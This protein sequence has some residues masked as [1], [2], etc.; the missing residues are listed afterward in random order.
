ARQSLVAVCSQLEPAEPGNKTRLATRLSA[1]ASRAVECDPA[2]ANL[3]VGNPSCC[4]DPTMPIARAIDR[5]IGHTNDAP[6]LRTALPG[7]KAKEII[8]SDETFVSPSYTRAYPLV[9]DH[10]AGAVVE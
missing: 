5:P 7:P 3:V 8:E 9:V 10:A 2:T 1:K 6:R 4:E